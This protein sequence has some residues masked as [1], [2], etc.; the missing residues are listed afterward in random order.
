MISSKLKSRTSLYK[1]TKW[2]VWD[3]EKAL[4]FVDA[5]KG[6]VDG[7][8][9]LLTE[10][11]KAALDAET[12]ALRIAILGTICSGKCSSRDIISAFHHFKGSP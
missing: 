8:N 5:I 11:Q 3:G 12:N 4:R 2:A 7:L 1:K 9:K 6:Y 10:S